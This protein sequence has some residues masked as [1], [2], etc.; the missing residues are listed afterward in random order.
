MGEK[1]QRETGRN[2]RSEFC[3]LREIT[4]RLRAI[5]GNVSGKQKS[6]G[7]K[8]GLFAFSLQEL[9]TDGA[10][11]A[12]CCR[13]CVTRDSAADSPPSCPRPST[14]RHSLRAFPPFRG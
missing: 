1:G 12:S 2:R 6:P 4:S 11:C 10:R 3:D 14:C 13:C 5:A 8:P 9:L 7:L